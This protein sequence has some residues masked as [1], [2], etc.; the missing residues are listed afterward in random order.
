MGIS[1]HSCLRKVRILKI[2]SFFWFCSEILASQ[3]GDCR[4]QL[5]PTGQHFEKWCPH[6]DV[7][8]FSDFLASQAR[9]GSQ[10]PPTGQNSKRCCPFYG[11]GRLFRKFSSPEGLLSPWACATPAQPLHNPWTTPLNPLA[12]SFPK[13]LFQ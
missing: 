13:Q 7:E 5:P 4:S 2:V 8:G 3:V 9:D 11:F 10:L 6:F 12:Q 1:C